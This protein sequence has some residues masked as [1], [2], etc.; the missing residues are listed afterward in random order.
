MAILILLAAIIIGVSEYKQ[1]SKS[2]S[3]ITQEFTTIDNNET[4]SN[5]LETTSSISSTKQYN[6]KLKTNFTDLFRDYS[7]DSLSIVLNPDG[8]YLITDDAG[9]NSLSG[10]F[11]AFT[12][13]DALD[14]KILT[15]KELSKI[16]IA[17]NDY[18]IENIYYIRANY[19][20]HIY[21]NNQE[22]YSFDIFKPQY[23]EFVIC[24]REDD[25]SYLYAIN[26]IDNKL[27]TTNIAKPCF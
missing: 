1:N 21:G 12:C 6:G 19:E 3:D 22:F 20:S 7:F 5:I 14:K 23:Y 11:E 8:Y 2:N 26:N 27:S 9:I 15:K 25:N 16:G 18:Q 4:T 13:S 24:F 10:K 17:C